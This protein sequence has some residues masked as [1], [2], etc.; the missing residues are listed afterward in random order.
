MMVAGISGAVIVV[1]VV[2]WY[3]VE[4]RRAREQQRA[5]TPQWLSDLKY[6]RN[7]DGD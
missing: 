6:P 3:V 5:V 2:A 7:G 1:A 4:K